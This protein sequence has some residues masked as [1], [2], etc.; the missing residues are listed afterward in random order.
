MLLVFES[1]LPLDG[2]AP[3]DGTEMKVLTW[4]AANAYTVLFIAFY[5]RV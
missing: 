4:H 5:C 2:P 3:G 1:K